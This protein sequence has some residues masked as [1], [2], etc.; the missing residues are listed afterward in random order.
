MRNPHEKVERSFLKIIGWTIAIVLLLSVGGVFGYQSFRAWQQRKLIAQGNAFVNLGDYK[1][2][3]LNARRILQLNPQNPEGLRLLARVAEKTNSSSAIEIRRRIME[4]GAANAGDLIDLARDAVRS[5][6]RSTAD[7]AMSKLPADANERADYHALM[8]EIAYAKRDGATMERELSEAQRIDPKNKEYAIR[9]AALRLSANDP[10]ISE[11]GR[12]ALLQL[13]NDPS[14]RREATRHLAENAL[15]RRDFPEAVKFARQ[16]DSFPDKTFDDRLVLLS[17]LK[18]A[19]DPAFNSLL[20]EMQQSATDDAATAGTLIGWM[21]AN[22]LAQDAIN[23]GAKLPPQELGEK[24]VPV[25]LSDAYVAVG[26]WKGLQRLTKSGNW[27]NLDFLRVA[28][29]ARALR[30]L[31]DTAESTAQ[32]AE[33]VRKI[34]GNTREILLLAETVEKW[35]WRGESIQLL[36]RAS[37]DPSQG[38]EALQSLYEYFAKNGDTQNLYRVLVRRSDRH[39]EDTT[40]KNNVA[41]LSLLLNLNVERGRELAREVYQKDPHNPNYVSTYAFSLYANADAQKARQVMETLSDA[42]LRQPELAAYYG[43]ILAATGDTQ[44]ASEFLDLG[45]K[46]HLLP[47]EK[48]LVERARRSIAQH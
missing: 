30:E 16:L 24:L 41:Q 48:A 12:A 40:T 11:Q 20:N 3:G 28:L 21:T 26:D 4:M 34:P 36:W 46:A 18:A 25:A 7:V 33:A 1:R 2:A 8:A 35:G 27:G 5:G 44:R 38:E 15:T 29:Q 19:A 17:A 31:G 43:M 47:E 32:W 14:L 10:K 22:G 9:L 6:D 42:Q 23:W 37:E 13:Q 39:P 45:E